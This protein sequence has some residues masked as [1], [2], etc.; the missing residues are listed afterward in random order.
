MS[1]GADTAAVAASTPALPPRRAPSIVLLVVCQT[2]QALAFGGIAL[3]LPLIRTD[4]GLTF[5]EA[6]ALS[7][8]STLVYSLMQIPSGYLSD[9]VG[10][11]RLFVIGLLGTNI[12]TFVFALLDNYWAMLGNQA[13]SGFFRALIFA[14]GILL[15]AG[16]FPPDRRATAIGLFVAGGFSSSLFLNLLGP[17]LVDPLGWRTLFMAFA[18]GGL[19]VLALYWR[20]GDEG[21]RGR[22]DAVSPKEAL[23]LFR[24]PVMWM[25]GVIQYVRLAVVFGVMFWLPSFMVDE[26]GYSLRFAGL[27]VALGAVLAAPANLIGGYVSDRLH[28]PLLVIRVSLVMLALTLALLA[29][30]HQAV[31]LVLV[32][33]VNAIFLQLYFG[34]LFALPIEL[35]GPRTAGLA[36]GFGNFFANVGGFTFTFALGALKDATGSF[37]VGFYCLVVLCAI[38]MTATFALARLRPTPAPDHRIAAT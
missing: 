2:M 7:A 23:Q 30:V 1:T 16:L 36:S 22:R 38:S 6:G 32:V 18:I 17:I 24:Y 31:A 20:Y 26:L 35:L 37:D 11:K 9:R 19:L 12:L 3:F 15:I 25:V 27:V 14:P 4:V 21:P 8:A 13:I 29:N 10:P 28:N 33:A 5:S 34:P